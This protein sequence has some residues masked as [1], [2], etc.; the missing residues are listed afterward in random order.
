MKTLLASAILLASSGVYAHDSHN[1]CDVDLD[2]GIRINK[3]DIEFSNNKELVYKIVGKETLVVDGEVI[4]LT[5]SQQS[6]VEDYA[7]SIYDVVPEVHS[8]VIE[9]LDMA[10]DGVTMAFNELLGEGNNVGRDLTD[11]LAN[12][13]DEL[14]ARFSSEDGFYIDQD[15][16]D[17]GEFFGED[18]ENRIES[19][20][21][22][23]VMSSMGSILVAVGQEM[24]MSGGNNG[25]FET[26]MEAFGERIE[27]EMESRGEKISE[28]ADQ[29]CESAINIDKLEEQLKDE[30]SEINDYNFVTVRNNHK[31]I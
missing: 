11:E 20:V 18:F 22:D 12:I 13:R 16:I 24:L 17:S 29:L 27:H 2:G 19:V 15:G 30:I 23:A 7:N 31:S 21:E 14:D 9:G 1:S 28:K 26:R 4:A 3:N 25:N 10:T 5:A 6:L 8:I